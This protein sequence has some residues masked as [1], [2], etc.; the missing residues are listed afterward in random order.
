M[1]ASVTSNVADGVSDV[2]ATLTGRLF[3]WNSS[4]NLWY[5]AA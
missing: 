3:I 1:A 2:I 5:R 4:T